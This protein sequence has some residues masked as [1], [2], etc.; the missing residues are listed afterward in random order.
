MRDSH[1][2]TSRVSDGEITQGRRPAGTTKCQEVAG[3]K[4]EGLRV[5]AGYGSL[6]AA[7][8]KGSR[9]LVSEISSITA[10]GSSVMKCHLF[11]PCAAV[12]FC[13]EMF[14]AKGRN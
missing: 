12:V 14:I 11:Q 5:G 6:S 3:V 4:V 2:S 8:L 9:M 1:K 13:E 10:Q 7:Y